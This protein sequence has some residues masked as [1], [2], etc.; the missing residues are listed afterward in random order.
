LSMRLGRSLQPF[1]RERPRA[2]SAPTGG[3]ELVFVDTAH[4]EQFHDF[5]K[6]HQLRAEEKGRFRTFYSRGAWIRFARPD[7]TWKD[8]KTAFRKRSLESLKSELAYYL[9]SGTA[10]H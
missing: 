9:I 7:A 10:S 6:T 8:W 1:D 3:A 4:R 2:A 5:V